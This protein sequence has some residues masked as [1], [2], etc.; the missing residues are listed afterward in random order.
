MSKNLI[1]IH[2]KEYINKLISKQTLS[3]RII[4]LTS[5][6]CNELKQRN[7][8]H[9][10]A[11]SEIDE[12]KLLKWFNKWGNNFKRI[13]SH[14][15]VSIWWL[16]KSWIYPIPTYFTPLKIV[17]RDIEIIKA[18]L[19]KERPS[20]II[21]VNDGTETS[22]IIKAVSEKIETEEI[23]IPHFIADIK[24][25]LRRNNILYLKILRGLLRKSYWFVLRNIYR[26]QKR[27]G[28]KVLFSSDGRWNFDLNLSTHNFE[29][30]DIYCGPILNMLSKE[31]L[32][33][34]VHLVVAEDIGVRD[35][36]DKIRRGTDYVPFEKYI[37]LNSILK[38]KLAQKKLLKIWRKLKEQKELFYYKGINVYKLL[39]PPLDFFFSKYLLEFLIYFEAIE[40]MIELEKPEVMVIFSETDPFGRIMVAMARKKKIPCLGI[41]HGS[42]GIAEGT[43]IEDRSDIPRGKGLNFPECPIPH[44]TAVYGESA[45]EILVKYNKYN[46]RSIVITGQ[47]RYDKFKHLDR[48]YSKENICKRL[49]LDISKKIIVLATTPFYSKREQEEFV[50]AAYKAVKNLPDVQ[51]IVKVHPNETDISIYKMLAEKRKL[52]NF[53]IIRDV[54]IYKL[55]YSSDLMIGGISTTVIDASVLNKPVIVLDPTNKDLYAQM[56]IKSGAVLGAS[57]TKEILQAIKDALFNPTTQEK[58]EKRR[59]EF[60]SFYAYRI[61]GRASERINSLIE[62]MAEGE[63]NGNFLRR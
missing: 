46:P 15:D 20:K 38:A 4:G 29:K 43:F 14:K 28:R 3:T 62:R 21:F 45:K 25:N 6:V 7:I 61:D 35:F 57:N 55:L 2:N 48:I 10:R 40:R 39:L 26:K 44:I 53:K 1:L 33:T 47:P 8:K 24:R 34:V 13:F 31:W 9:K 36:I 63:Y 27:T 59:K 19:N 37:H 50:E 30:N 23:K 51:L 54:D 49:G 42:I 41:Q 17:L 16:L 60:I 32:P 11:D 12:L 52:E 5:E 56:Y 22:E 58:L 18:L